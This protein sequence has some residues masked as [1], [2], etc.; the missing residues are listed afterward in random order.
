MV[1]MRVE[2]NETEGLNPLA[3]QALNAQATTISPKDKDSDSSLMPLSCS[4]ISSSSVAKEEIEAAFSSKAAAPKK[5][6]E[7]FFSSSSISSS[8]ESFSLEE[9]S[10][11]RVHTYSSL[12]EISEKLSL[13]QIMSRILSK[14]E[15]VENLSNS[16]R[17][18]YRQI[19]IRGI[20]EANTSASEQTAAKAQMLSRSAFI[21]LGVALA[22]IPIPVE[23][24]KQLLHT[25]A[26]S[27]GPQWTNSLSTSKDGS[28]KL[29][30]DEAQALSR[31]EYN[32]TSDKQKDQ[33][34]SKISA[35]FD[36]IIR[37]SLSVT[38]R[39]G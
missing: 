3:L 7:D 38:T 31:E 15:D 8:K 1:T 29:K 37:A 4:S 6:S 10:R 25:V 34:E 2:N 35:L 19:L 26:N 20:L 5:V 22:P 23:S 16:E 32:L 13:L 30:S 18:V 21:L 17:R 9:V 12:V 14:V 33:L 28:I 39:G 36:A 24:I 27:L 11:K